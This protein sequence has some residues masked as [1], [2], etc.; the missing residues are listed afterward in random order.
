LEPFVDE[1]Y[2]FVARVYFH[3]SQVQKFLESIKE[4]Y[5]TENI[6]TY[7]AY[8][9]QALTAKGQP[10]GTRLLWEPGAEE[11]LR[12]DA[13]RYRIWIQHLTFEVTD[14]EGMIELEAS[15]T[16]RG[17]ARLKYGT[18]SNFYRTVVQLFIGL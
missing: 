13:R 17:V 5:D 12:T 15:L 4:T 3:Y 6:V 10:K 18:Y 8:K 1:L 2:P 16:T 9:R 11:D 7:V 14:S